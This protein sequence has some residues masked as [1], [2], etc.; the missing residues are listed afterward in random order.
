MDKFIPS[1]GGVEATEQAALLARRW[2]YNIKGVEAN[3][4]NVVIPTGGFW[5]RSI[6]A[7]SGSDCPMRTRGAGPFTPG[8]PL[9]P[10]N[11]VEAMEEYLKNDPNCVAVMLEPIQGERGIITPQDG[12]LLKIK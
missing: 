12:Y 8:F 3:M 1:N 11:D 4:A 5:G 10:Y 2:G 6:T 7:R 9:V